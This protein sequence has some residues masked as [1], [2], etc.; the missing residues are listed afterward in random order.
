MQKMMFPSFQKRNPCVSSLVRDVWALALSRR[1]GQWYAMVFE[2]EMVKPVN[3]CTIT[4][5]SPYSL[6]W[7]A[8]SI[9]EAEMTFSRDGIGDTEALVIWAVVEASLLIPL[10]VWSATEKTWLLLMTRIGGG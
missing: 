3:S 6:A 9:S 1:R 2:T 4:R 5:E 10:L 8:N 7:P